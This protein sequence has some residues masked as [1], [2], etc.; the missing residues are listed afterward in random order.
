M[1]TPVRR[2]PGRPRKHPLPETPA[3]S[4]EV[5]ETPAPS[6]EKP[7][8]KKAAKPPPEDPS[9]PRIGLECHLTASHVGF[10]DG[11]LYEAKDGFVVK[12]VS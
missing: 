4:T 3:P 8:P 7:E 11:S 1:T 2:G 5:S 6:I 12:R 10:E 9:D